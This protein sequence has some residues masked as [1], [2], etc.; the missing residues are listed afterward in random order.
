MQ[1]SA[2][3]ESLAEMCALSCSCGQVTKQ[4][5][6]GEL[7]WYLASDD[8]QAGLGGGQLRTLLGVRPP[9]V[10]RTLVERLQAGHA[11]VALQLADAA[12]L[13]QTRRWTA[14]SRSS[15]TILC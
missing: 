5:W 9:H 12:D 13:L 2:L 10:A 14:A 6:E 11:E 8:Q 4:L 1:V 15:G 7:L 3:P